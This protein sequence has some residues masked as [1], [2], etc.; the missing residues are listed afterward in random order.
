[1]DPA[2]LSRTGNNDPPAAT[3]AQPKGQTMMTVEEMAEALA[4][5]M[6]DH[7]F[8]FV[9]NDKLPALTATLHAF[10]VTAGL[11]IN[12]PELPCPAGC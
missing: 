5:V 9:E 7:G 6:C 3:P 11:P 2:D 10:L 4:D 12:P 8:A 1:M